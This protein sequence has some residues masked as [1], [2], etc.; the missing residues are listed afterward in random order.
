M[1]M[2]TP[3]NNAQDSLKKK[4]SKDKHFQPETRGS[5]AIKTC[6]HCQKVGH[7]HSECCLK[8]PGKR[9]ASRVR[10]K[11]RIRMGLVPPQFQNIVERYSAQTDKAYSSGDTRV[12]DCVPATAEAAAVA[13]AVQKIDIPSEG[14]SPVE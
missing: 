12:L 7:I 6:Y 4:K 2:K 8:F 5:N 14:E 9:H 11:T 3:V 13:A 1:N 10:I